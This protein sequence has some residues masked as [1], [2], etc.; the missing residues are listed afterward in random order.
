VGTATA[1]FIFDQAF[2]LDI[3]TLTKRN[4]ATGSAGQSKSAPVSQSN[5]TPKAIYLFDELPLNANG[6]IDRVRLVRLLKE[7]RNEAATD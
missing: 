7:K 2:I 4:C 3:P 1:R 5:V 6:K